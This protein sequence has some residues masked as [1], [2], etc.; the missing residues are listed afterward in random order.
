MSFVV[1]TPST[2]QIHFMFAPH[3]CG[4]LG[5]LNMLYSQ[6]CGMA[7]WRINYL[8]KHQWNGV[9]HFGHL[10][11]ATIKVIKHC[12]WYMC[13]QVPKIHAPFNPNGEQQI[14]YSFPFCMRIEVWATRVPLFFLTQRC[15][16]PNWTWDVSPIY[17]CILLHLL[18]T[19]RKHLRYLGPWC[20]FVCPSSR[21]LLA[22]LQA[23]L[24][25]A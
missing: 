22:F 15:H 9:L 16:I 8:Y 23:L 19:V 6:C 13:W 14:R 7:A 17:T 20:P 4:L 3:A 5:V 25:F 18:L 10:L 2:F 12:V 24:P 21:C 1:L 11:L